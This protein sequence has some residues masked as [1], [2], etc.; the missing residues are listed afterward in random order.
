MTIQVGDVVA[1]MERLFPLE[2]AESWDRVG[3]SVGDP[4][5]PVSSVGFAVD[6]CEES[7]QE[8]ITRGADM[9]ITHHPLY[10]RG[11]HSVAT[12]TAKGT[13]TSR[14]IK[15]DVALY[16]AHTNADVAVSTLALAE[17]LSVTL[18]R[19]LDEASGIGGVG[20]IEPLTLREFGSV[21]PL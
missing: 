10:L 3:L 19:P 8:A 9:L 17:L 5:I 4:S 21:W 11:T 6:P 12:T 2:T 13:W 15:N 20:S 16:T 1:A 18:E 14:L 7:V